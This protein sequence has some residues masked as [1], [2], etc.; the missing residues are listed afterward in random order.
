[1]WSELPRNASTV[2]HI[3]LMVSPRHLTQVQRLLYS[4]GIQYDVVLSDIEAE[5]ERQRLS[6]EDETECK[7]VFLTKKYHS[8]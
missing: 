5:I 4:I 7:F 3:D 1:M 8:T 2:T 6:D